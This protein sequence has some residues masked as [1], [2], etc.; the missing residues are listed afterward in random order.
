MR[1][2]GRRG[3]AGSEHS[4][5][6]REGLQSRGAKNG[7]GPEGDCECREKVSVCLLLNFNE[8]GQIVAC[9]YVNGTAH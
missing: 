6:L 2:D 3:I 1:E 8:R 9:L 5:L 7:P 4:Q